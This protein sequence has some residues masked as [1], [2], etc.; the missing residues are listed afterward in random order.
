MTPTTENHKLLLLDALNAL[1]TSPGGNLRTQIL[2]LIP[3]WDELKNIGINL[4]PAELATSARDR[5]LYYLRRYPSTIISHKEIMIVAG[6]SEWARRVRELRVQFGWA[7]MSGTTAR[8]MQAAGEISAENGT[9]DCSAM[10]P[11]TIS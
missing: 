7:V 9:P 6:I 4:I 11:E 1:D 2:A 5:I 3:A 10:K 8:E